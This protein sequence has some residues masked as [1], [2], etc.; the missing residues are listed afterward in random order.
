MKKLAEQ[1]SIKE[2]LKFGVGGG[3]AVV[4]DFV[5]Y[6]LL[7][8]FLPVSPSKAISYVSGAAVGFIINKMWTFES[9]NFR[10]SEIIKYIVLYAF[11]AFANTA[12][13]KGILFISSSI[14]FA[15]LCATATS[16]II[17]FLG[18]KFVVFSGGR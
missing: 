4:V 7:K 1:F 11:S 15:F 6:I 16:T 2:I 18:Q 10:I 3:S 9:K 12:V 5:L 14:I 17:N 13:N 8:N